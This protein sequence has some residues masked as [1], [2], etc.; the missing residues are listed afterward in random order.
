M[1][2]LVKTALIAGLLAALTVGPALAEGRPIVPN[3]GRP[4]VP[5]ERGPIWP[6][7]K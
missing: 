5:A 7:A 3:E 1:H 4:I 6:S 2:K